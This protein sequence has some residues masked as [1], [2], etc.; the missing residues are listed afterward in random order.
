MRTALNATF[1]L[2]LPATTTFDYPSVT[3][4]AGYITLQLKDAAEAPAA[5]ATAHAATAGQAT[6]AFHADYAGVPKHL[7]RSVAAFQPTMRYTAVTGTA[8]RYPCTSE[9]GGLAPFW[10][11]LEHGAN[12]PRLM[13]LQRWDVDQ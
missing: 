9:F 3:A 6:L 11:L 8:G 2:D 4:L 1:D 13:P 12:L 10:Q 5:H 7:S